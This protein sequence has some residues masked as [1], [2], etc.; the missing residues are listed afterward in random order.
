[1]NVFEQELFRALAWVHA[2]LRG[3]GADAWGWAIVLLT[4]A[5][6]LLVLPLRLGSMR[7]GVKMQRIQPAIA[8]IQQRYK[9]VPLTDPRQRERSAEIAQLQ[10]ESGVNVL[11]GCVPLL[12]QMPLLLAFFGMLRK[13]PALHGAGWL[14]L[15]DLSAPDPYHVLPVLMGVCQLLVQWTTPS[16]GS[17]ARQRKM[18]AVLTTVAFGY[19]S[20]HYASGIA[21]YALTGSIFSLATQAAMN[22]SERGRDA[23]AAGR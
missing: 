2:G 6:N 18:V 12:V 13:A 4:G 8:A 23:R 22:R 16:P 5:I 1:M 19:A 9:T 7:S 10:R 20:W 3:R 21:L 11:G 14:W 17:D 15:H